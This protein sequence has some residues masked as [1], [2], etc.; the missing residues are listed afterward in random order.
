MENYHI[1]SVIK[2]GFTLKKKNICNV[3]TFK[4]CY[5]RNCIFILK[6]LVLVQWKF[7]SNIK[8]C[9]FTNWYFK[10]LNSVISHKTTVQT[11]CSG[12]NAIFL[13]KILLENI[14][15]SF[16]H[17]LLYVFGKNTLKLSQF[18]VTIINITLYFLRVF[19]LVLILMGSYIC[20]Y[21]VF[22]LFIYKARLSAV[23]SWWSEFYL[24]PLSNLLPLIYCGLGDLLNKTTPIWKVSKIRINRFK[25]RT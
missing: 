8:L 25:Q 9:F 21:R 3:C 18:K 23:T 22:S 17:I 20:F 1:F 24:H 7:L 15:K 6:F 14:L 13:F 11:N 12:A 16:I 10:I 4:I 5:F 19:V 2:M